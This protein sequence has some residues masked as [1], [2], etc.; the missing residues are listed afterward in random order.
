MSVELTG[1]FIVRRV[2]KKTSAKFFNGLRVGDVF[3]LRYDLNGQYNGAP[4]IDIYAFEKLVH[5]T[6]ALQLSKNL[7]NFE[8]EEHKYTG[9]EWR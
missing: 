3:E 7:T 4:T 9:S 1:G 5:T 8:L 6:N 2:K